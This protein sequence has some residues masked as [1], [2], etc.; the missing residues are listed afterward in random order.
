MFAPKKPKPR[1]SKRRGPDVN[2]RAALRLRAG[3][4]APALLP[5]VVRERPVGLGHPVGVFLLLDRVPLALRSQDQLRGEPLGPGLL[6]AGAGELDQPAHGQCGPPV[7]ADLHR[8]LER[9][10]ADPPAL[11]LE[12]R[13]GVVDR[14]LEHGHARLPRP[15]LDQVHGLVEDALGLALLAL[16]HE[17]VDELRDRLTVVSRIG[18]DRPL[19]GLGPPAHLAPPLAPAALGRLAPYLD[20][21]W[22]RSFTPAASRVPRTM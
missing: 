11:H 10:P 8:N 1:K 12:R 4:G 14:L 19:D 9:G 22:R 3:P 2:P 17:V 16:V 18:R 20:R 13:L 7:R 5:A 15:L 6:G 21:P